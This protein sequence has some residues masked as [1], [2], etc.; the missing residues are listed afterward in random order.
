MEQGQSHKVGI[1]INNLACIRGNR[2]I[3]QTITRNI[4]S[5]ET[6]WVKGRNGSG[7]STFLR[8]TSGLLPIA[9][10]TIEKLGTIAFC[11][12]KLTLDPNL[13]LEKALRFWADLDNSSLSHLDEAMEMFDLILLS[14]IPV[15]LLSTGQR[16]RANLARIMAS[17]ADIYM[18]DEPYNGL[19]SD[20]VMALN[21]AIQWHRK[22]GGI[23]VIASHIEPNI[24]IDH[25]LDLD[26]KAQGNIV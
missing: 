13:G 20:N 24:A 23:V 7:K 18:L 11:D 15:R 5:G 19:D 16:K 25:V 2:L 1:S 26:H 21:K 14:K 10:G 3:Y 22:K 8:Q 17:Q 6:L 4:V 9:T 12:E